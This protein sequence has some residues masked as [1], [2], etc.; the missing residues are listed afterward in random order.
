ML[1]ALNS[2]FFFFHAMFSNRKEKS[3]AVNKEE[4]KH[5]F[6]IKTQNFP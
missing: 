5:T 6:K 3:T 2:V 4:L 1:M